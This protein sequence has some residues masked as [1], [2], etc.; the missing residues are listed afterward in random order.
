[1]GVTMCL[2][3]TLKICEWDNNKE[4]SIDTRCILPSRSQGC[5]RVGQQ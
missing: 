3:H 5:M 2:L 1:M 4:S